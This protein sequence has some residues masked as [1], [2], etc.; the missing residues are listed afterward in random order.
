MR[1]TVQIFGPAIT[2]LNHVT[3]R[4]RVIDRITVVFKIFSRLLCF[5]CFSCNPAM[6]ATRSAPRGNADGSRGLG[7]AG[8]VPNM[9]FI[10]TDDAAAY[11]H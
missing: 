5:L 4:D 6:T 1:Y 7:H 10:L 8:P 9:D 3:I 2:I 11:I